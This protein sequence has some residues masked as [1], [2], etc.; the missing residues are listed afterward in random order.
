MLCVRETVGWR[1]RIWVRLHNTSPSSAPAPHTRSSN[2]QKA[3]HCKFSWSRSCL[4]V[5]VPIMFYRCSLHFPPGRPVCGSSLS[6]FR[7]ASHPPTPHMFWISYDNCDFEIIYLWM[8][9]TDP[10]CS[11]R[12]SFA[13]QS[14]YIDF[15]IFDEVMI[16]ALKFT[17]NFTLKKSV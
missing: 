3:H 13:L 12:K 17:I 14:I 2:Q 9:W 8:F 11:L 5:F 7:V 1:D 15:W 10:L 16:Y 6:L 4:H